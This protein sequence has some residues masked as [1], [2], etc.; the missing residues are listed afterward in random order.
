LSHLPFE[1][2]KGFSWLILLPYALL[3]LQLPC[4]ID[5]SIRAKNADGPF[6]A[7]RIEKFGVILNILEKRCPLNHELVHVVLISHL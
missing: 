7:K 2:S 4:G 5:I 1:Q 6:Q 3:R